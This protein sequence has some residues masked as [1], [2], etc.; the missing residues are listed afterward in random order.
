MPSCQKDEGDFRMGHKG[1]KVQIS[2]LR[3]LA[4]IPLLVFGTFACSSGQGSEEQVRTVTKT[5]TQ[6]VDTSEPASG[7]ETAASTREVSAADPEENSSP[8]QTAPEDILA[9]QYRYINQG[10]YERAYDTFTP[11]S[12]EIVSLDQ[13]IAFFEANAPYT[14]DGYSFTSTGVQGDTAVIDTTIT[15][16]SAN[17]SDYSYSVTQEMVRTGGDWRAIMRDD[18]IES[19]TGSAP[20]SQQPRPQEQK[21]TE[22]ESAPREGN[23]IVRVTGNEAFSG[24]YGNIDSSRTVDGVAPAEYSLEVDTGLFSADVVS[25]VM[26]KTGAGSGELGIQ[27][28]VDGEVVQ[29]SSTTA[30]YGVAQVSWTPGE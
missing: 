8:T 22:P 5:V 6:T 9:E 21:A 4:L 3:I 13:Y 29:E 26:Q 18:Q 2:L 17:V 16:T 30:E 20:S 28:V 1:H 23:V 10:R 14:V 7:K 15:V 11:Q 19:F 24:N 27:I 12:Q 25:V